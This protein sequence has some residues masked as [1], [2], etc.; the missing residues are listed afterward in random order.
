MI[1]IIGAGFAG[2]LAANILRHRKPTILEA[3]A[4]LPNN[5]SAVLRFRS[6]VVGDVTGIE[7]KEVNV[8]K[9]SLP[10][11]NSIADPLAYADKNSGILR[12]D[13]S[14]PSNI[15]EAKRYI[16]P[17][18]LIEQLAEGINIRYSVKDIFIGA[19]G[20]LIP[21]ISTI[22]MPA[23]M[24]LLEYP[25]MGKIQFNSISGT[26]LLAKVA[27]CDAYVS[28]YCPN[29]GYP[30]SRVSLMGD[31]LVAEVPIATVDNVDLEAI[32]YVAASLLGI[33]RDR[34]SDIEAKTQQYAKIQ[35]ID[36]DARKRFI[37][38]CSDK[39]NIW[40]LGRYGCWR[41]PLLLDDLVKDIRLIERWIN[42]G[43]QSYARKLH[44]M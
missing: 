11:R 25:E 29:P 24:G 17:P 41:P 15:V 1:T 40:S 38:W 34:L 8:I 20:G 5:H 10:W 26:N 6:H 28:L 18:N 35:P 37:I 32:M 30:F 2:L 13:R 44:V 42:K 12:S 19:S 31:Q 36:D 4:S 23:L 33:A 14:I 39:H 22:P 7:F 9:A 43:G 27:R 3:Q 16:A 21:I